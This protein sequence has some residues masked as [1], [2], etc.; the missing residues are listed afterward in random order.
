MAHGDSL[1][2]YYSMTV[3]DSMSVSN[4]L[5]VLRLRL[6]FAQSIPEVRS[7]EERCPTHQRAFSSTGHAHTHV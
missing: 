7:E 3:H 4:V 6:R 1:R 5:P 2:T